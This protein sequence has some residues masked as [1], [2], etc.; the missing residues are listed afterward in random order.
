MERHRGNHHAA[1]IHLKNLLQKSPQHAEA[2]YLLGVIYLEV[3]DAV[4][5][6]WELRRAIDL[7]YDQTKVIP[8]LG[9]S[10]LMSGEFQKVLDEVRL[11]GN[12]GEVQA[13]VL[14]LR[15]LA[16]IGLGHKQIGR[17]LLEQALALKPGFADA[18]LGQARLAASEQR[19][20]E[21]AAL[22]ARALANGLENVDAWL[23]KGE[24]SRFANDRHGA[25]VAYQKVLALRPHSIR[26]RL[27]IASLHIDSGDYDEARRQVVEIRKLVPRSPM[28]GYLDA[29]IA[30]RQRDYAVARGAVLRAL[31]V[32]PDHMPSVL[33]RG[34]VEFAQGSQD[35]A[36][37][38]LE[39][40]VQRAP[41]NLYARRL[42]IASLAKSGKTQ[43]AL[44]ILEPALPQYPEDSAL[45]ALAGEVYL[46]SNQ[47]AKASQFF[48]KAATL[49]RHNAG[50][51]TGVGLTR[52]ALGE[53]DDALRHFESASRMDSSQSHADVL[54]ITLHLRRANYDAALKAMETLERKQPD[55]P[56][57]YNLKAAIY[58]GKK[59]ARTARTYLSRALELNPL[60]VPAAVTLA[61]LDIEE[62]KP[63]AARRRLEAIL[64]KD[65]DNVEAL[66]SLASFGRRIGAT[67]DE[68]IAWLNRATRASPR[69]TRPPLMLARLHA[70]AGNAAQA[71]AA[72]GWAQVISPDN[73]E[74]LYLLG[75]IQVAAG[76]KELAL[77]TY[78]RIASLQP[79][80][81]V[82]LLRLA[83]ALAA[84]ADDSAAA[85]ALGRA[86]SLK[87]DYIDAQVA[88]A[89]L[90]V[91]AG[92]LSEAKAIARQLKEQ[93][94]TFAIG[95]SL[96]GDVLMAQKR[97]ADA[98]E[99]YEA[100]YRTGKSGSL[101]IRMHKAY[102]QAGNAGDAENRLAQLVKDSADDAFVRMY[103]ADV[104][105]RGGKYKKAVE[106]YE[107]LL[108]SQRDNA[109]A[110][111]N[112]ALAYQRMED[113][114]ALETAERAYRLNPKNAE[115]IDTLGWILVEQGNSMRGL[116]LL[117]RAVAAAPTN[118][119]FRYHLAQ[120]WLKVGN[121]TKARNELK[122]LLSSN[123]KFPQQAEAAQ[124]FEQLRD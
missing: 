39:R 28:A 47:F 11:E 67:R 1:V 23:M 32:A 88:L 53:T 3:D 70:Q 7:G 62:K 17:E 56:L 74:V 58:L 83:N 38:Y 20:E 41:D 81:P 33:L 37:Q 106:H 63:H 103:A 46:L 111:N 78:R 31:D 89:H 87:P 75:S 108:Q 40:V 55:N 43:R 113:P 16:A 94:T 29:L 93:E 86:L 98:A 61:Q 115:I 45:M 60:Y 34:V 121:T 5:A 118:H 57:T 42:L 97:F 9:Q 19:Q 6:Q 117:Q 54:L 22:V 82:A 91:R 112:L 79:D 124:L 100:A 73:L 4:S 25:L 69:S 105:F 68:Q 84:S 104:A 122:Q 110:L 95:R 14:T 59:D 12:P 15:A 90:H 27:S 30:F 76:Q 52:L 26:A 119:E 66:L 48:E 71:L 109:V 85:S 51:R 50:A 123:A 120:A 36:Q 65:K 116:E 80:S 13:E 77:T 2:R 35:M 18:L 21:A 49:D 72:A 44:D 102:V 64:E 10:L 107:W 114:R 101:A 99:A 24:L 8:T 96:E 92:K